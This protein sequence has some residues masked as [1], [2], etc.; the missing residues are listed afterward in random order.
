MHFKFIEGKIKTPPSG[1]YPYLRSYAMKKHGKT[2]TRVFY[3]KVRFFGL[4]CT[5]KRKKTKRV[6]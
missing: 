6:R 5:I 3:L 2:S 1:G 4:K